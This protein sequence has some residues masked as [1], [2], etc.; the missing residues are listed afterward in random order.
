MLARP[1]LANIQAR[2]LPFGQDSCPV[3]PAPRQGGRPYWGNGKDTLTLHIIACSLRI[4]VCSLHIIACSLHVIACTLHSAS[5]QVLSAG[6]TYENSNVST[7][8]R[9][10]ATPSKIGSPSCSPVRLPKPIWSKALLTGNKQRDAH[11]RCR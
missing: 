6:D 11:D 7:H 5:S 10:V 2:C 4:I 1:D 3:A 9:G 8:T